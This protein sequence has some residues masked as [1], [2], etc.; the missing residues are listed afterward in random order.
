MKLGAKVIGLT[1]SIPSDSMNSEEGWI[2]QDNTNSFV[3]KSNL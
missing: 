3:E 1:I 2:N